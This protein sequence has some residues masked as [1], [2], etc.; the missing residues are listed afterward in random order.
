MQTH[1]HAH[2]HTH[3]YNGSHAIARTHSYISARAH[4]NTVRSS[5]PSAAPAAE[6][7][8]DKGG[9]FYCQY[10]V[11]T[12]TGDKKVLVLT[13]ESL[14]QLQGDKNNLRGKFNEQIRPVMNQ[15]NEMRDIAAVSWPLVLP[16]HS[17]FFASTPTVFMIYLKRFIL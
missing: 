8:A 4:N 6:D 1:T 14:E 13:P 10:C 3:A 7:G 16:S 15:V 9:Q 11:D 17:L 12:K 2:T 5:A